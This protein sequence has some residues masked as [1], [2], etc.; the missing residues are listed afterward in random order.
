MTTMTYDYAAAV[1]RLDADLGAAAVTREL[2][3]LRRRAIGAYRAALAHAAGRPDDS[4]WH[5]LAHAVAAFVARIP[6][7]ERAR[8]AAEV[9]RLARLVEEN[10]G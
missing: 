8:H 7:G 1:A 10:L 6:A 9:R 5:A 4:R 3:L 2:Q